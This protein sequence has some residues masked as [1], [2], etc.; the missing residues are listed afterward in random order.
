MDIGIEVHEDAF[1]YWRRH[2]TLRKP[3][4]DMPR[5]ER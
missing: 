5:T 3:P 2:D 4:K 1:A